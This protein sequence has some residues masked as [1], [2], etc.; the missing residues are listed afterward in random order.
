MEDRLGRVGGGIAAPRLPGRAVI[1]AAF[2]F[3]AFLQR[4]CRLVLQ[5]IE[6]PQTTFHLPPILLPSPAYG[7]PAELV[8]PSPSPDPRHPVLRRF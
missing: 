5:R 3:G 8:I 4:E 1:P 2:V 6:A 7:A